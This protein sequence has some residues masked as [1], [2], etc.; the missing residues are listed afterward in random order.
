MH[1][2]CVKI[3]KPIKGGYVGLQEHINN[4][5]VLL[6]YA[7]GTWIFNYWCLKSAPLTRSRLVTYMYDSRNTFT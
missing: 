7:W 6:E 4:I 1:D 2:M 5:I 3:G